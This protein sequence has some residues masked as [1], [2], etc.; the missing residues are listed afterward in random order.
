M[1]ILVIVNVDEDHEMMINMIMF[2]TVQLGD[3]RE[4]SCNWH[5][6]WSQKF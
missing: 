6:P 1:L 4:E 2:I 5:H 3:G